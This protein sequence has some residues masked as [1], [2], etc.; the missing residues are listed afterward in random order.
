MTP[1]NLLKTIGD[2]LKPII[3]ECSEC[4]KKEKE[5]LLN[6]LYESKG[7]FIST[8]IKTIEPLVNSISETAFQRAIYFDGRVKI[9][10]TTHV[11]EWCDIE[12]PI[13]PNRASRVDLI[14][15]TME[16]RG[17][18]CELKY[19]QK[20][21]RSISNNPYYSV[22]ELLV[23]HAIISVNYRL[24]DENKIR[25][26]GHPESKR[27]WEW[28]M[29]SFPKDPVLIMA[30][31]EDYWD[32]WTQLRNNGGAKS[33][34]KERFCETVKKWRNILKVKELLLISIPEPRPNFQIQQEIQQKLNGKPNYKAS[35][36]KASQKEWRIL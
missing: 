12:L 25:A 24:L 32:Y 34:V 33:I 16:K 18:L 27:D 36:G 6:K 26:N 7:P 20:N 4:D 10:N 1:S 30:A 8:P 29:L 22:L 17:V 19:M 15:K 23:Y 35:L 2:S 21:T 13:Q 5:G 9:F 11:I 28:E 3:S 14:G 31:N